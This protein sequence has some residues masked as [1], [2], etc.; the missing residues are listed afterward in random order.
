MTLTEIENWVEKSPQNKKWLNTAKK[1]S[2]GMDMIEFN[3]IEWGEKN[4]GVIALM[5]FIQ[6]GFHIQSKETYYLVGRNTPYDCSKELYWFLIDTMNGNNSDFPTVEVN[7][8][9]PTYTL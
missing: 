1:L 9:F 6:F 2:E 4:W 8:D 5:R 3:A 7:Y